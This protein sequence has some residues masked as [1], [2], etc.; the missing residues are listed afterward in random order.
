[1]NAG[2]GPGSLR[3]NAPP[4]TGVLEQDPTLPPL[5]HR[6]LPL[7]LLVA[8]TLLFAFA[9]SPLLGFILWPVF[10]ASPFYLNPVIT[11]AVVLYVGI[12]MVTANS[13]N[14]QGWP[15]YMALIG[16]WVLL[17]GF[18]FSIVQWFELQAGVRTIAAR[19]HP[20]VFAACAVA[21]GAAILLHGNQLAR[22]LHTDLRERGLDPEELEL[23][24]QESSRE[25]RTIVINLLALVAVASVI[26]WI[27][28]FLLAGTRLGLDVLGI[29]AGLLIVSV[30]LAYSYSILK[31][32]PGARDGDDDPPSAATTQRPGQ[33]PRPPT[34]KTVASTQPG[35]L[36]Q[37]EGEARPEANPES[38]TTR[39]QNGGEATW[40]RV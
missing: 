21:V 25:A 16:L 7:L 33:S 26:L 28:D 13:A 5:W 18:E 6:Q 9:V 1:M 36:P 35:R 37:R 19:V 30:I 38:S 27:A 12:G 15:F 40:R 17:V 14:D 32:G 23:L 11:V 3:L 10:W 29:L 39:E 24:E 8:G 20:I 22:R 34:A 31:Q 2:S 4:K